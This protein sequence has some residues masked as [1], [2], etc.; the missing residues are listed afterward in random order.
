[1]MTRMISRVLLC[2]VC[3]CLFAPQ[4][5]AE[6]AADLPLEI[7]ADSALEWNRDLHQYVARKNAKAVQGDFSVSADTL[8]ASYDESKGGGT[9]ITVLTAE[10]NVVITSGTS[11]ASGAKA[12]YDVVKGE[13]V[14]TGNTLKLVDKDLTVTAQEKFEYYTAE[15]KVI[16]Y[17]RP[18]I[19]SGDDTLEADHATAWLAPKGSATGGLQKAEATGNVII[20]TPSQTA[21]GDKATY[22]A[23]TSMANLIGHAK[24]MSGTDTLEGERAEV[25]L[26]T[27]VSRMVGAAGNGRVKGVF[28]P[29]NRRHKPAA[30]P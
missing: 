18:L 12:V 19:T 21:T 13:A 20:K 30:A 4:S 29:A 28:Y 16:A 15:G 8:T 23:P 22:D 10:G 9:S 14:L 26:K 1:M 3:V 25:N 17:G 7:T 11:H 24:V 2:S 5:F 6:P 27:K